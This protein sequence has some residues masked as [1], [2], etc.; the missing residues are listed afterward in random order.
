MRKLN[1][2]VL[3]KEYP[4]A[5][6]FIAA[7]DMRNLPTGHYDLEDGIYVNIDVYDTDSYE[8]RKYESHRRYLDIQYMISGEENMIVLPVDS[9]QVLEPYDKERDIEFYDR[10]VQGE[11]Y[12]VGEG[13]M[14]EF[15]PQD[16]HMPGIAVDGSMRVKKAVFK[17]PVK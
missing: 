15:M 9:L 16:G 4:A 8:N 14:M 5:A 7:H 3:E 12:T 13:E 10:T 6:K 17:I 1:L 11:S 2:T